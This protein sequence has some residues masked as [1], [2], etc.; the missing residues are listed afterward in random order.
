MMTEKEKRLAG[1]L[2]D[3]AAPELMEFFVQYKVF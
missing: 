1:E 3:P 2:Y